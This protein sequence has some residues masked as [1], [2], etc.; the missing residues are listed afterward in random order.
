MT[1]AEGRESPHPCNALLI[2]QQ[3]HPIFFAELDYRAHPSRETLNKWRE[4]VYETADFLSSFAY[5]DPASGRYV[6]GPPIFVVS[7]NTDPRVTTNPAFE[8]AY[9]RFGLRIAQTWRE[10][11]GERRNPTWDKV[12]Q[13][14]AP[15][16]ERDNVYVLYEGVRDMWTHYN[17]EHPVHDGHF[18]H[19]TG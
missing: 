14:L 18:R 19:F 17:F 3:P 9:W 16:P 11:L 1:S 2:W 4:I 15:L 13:R 7:E 12:L 5:F 6:L 8:L 10:R